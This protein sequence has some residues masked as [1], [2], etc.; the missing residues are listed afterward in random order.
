MDLLTKKLTYL[1][2]TLSFSKIPNYAVVTKQAMFLISK[3]L[4]SVALAC[5]GCAPNPLI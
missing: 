5:W 1:I 3:T 4:P 2:N